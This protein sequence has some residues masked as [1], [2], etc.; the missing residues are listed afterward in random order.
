MAACSEIRAIFLPSGRHREQK[1]VAFGQSRLGRMPP[2]PAQCVTQPGNEPIADTGRDLLRSENGAC[3]HGLNFLVRGVSGGA[4]VGIDAGLAE[5]DLG[6]EAG[7]AQ[8]LP[9]M[10]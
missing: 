5:V 8:S 4:A 7:S 1:D 9:D 10:G 2:R 6:C 3:A